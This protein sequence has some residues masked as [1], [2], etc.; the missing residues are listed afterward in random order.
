[1]IHNV[2]SYLSTWL[3]YWFYKTNIYIY[4]LQCI[5]IARNF[6]IDS[7]TDMPLVLL[8]IRSS[9]EESKTIYFPTS[10]KLQMINQNCQGADQLKVR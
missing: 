2:N 8:I 9:V 5:I 6:Y 1:M 3:T 10:D 7:D 4:I